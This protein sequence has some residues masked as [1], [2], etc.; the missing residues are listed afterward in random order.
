LNSEARTPARAPAKEKTEPE[1]RLLVAPHFAERTLHY[2]TRIILETTRTFATFRYELSVE[3]KIDAG[4]IALSILGFK[5]PHLTLPAAGPARF[6]K[7]YEGLKGAY[8]VIIEGIDGRE[9]SFS[10][11]ITP[12]KV[13][14]IKSPR[15]PFV[16]IVTDTSHWRSPIA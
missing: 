15:K 11:R 9:N 7:D 13:E 4:S 14:L 16:Q 10:I 5:T 1:Y 12:K 6:Q 8:N 3:E 2:V